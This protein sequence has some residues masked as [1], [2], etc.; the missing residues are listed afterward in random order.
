MLG[1]ALRLQTLLQ[2]ANAGGVAVSALE[3][4]QNSARLTWS[5]EEVDA[6][7][8]VPS[9]VGTRLGVQVQRQC[10]ASL[11][12]CPC[13]LLCCTVNHGCGSLCLLSETCHF[14]LE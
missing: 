12:E 4:A 7:L 2:A 10:S 3:M 13:L 5:S 1:C 11:H 8:K 9:L 6:K 14:E